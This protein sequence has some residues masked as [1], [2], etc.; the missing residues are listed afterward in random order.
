MK[1]AAQRFRDALISFHDGTVPVRNHAAEIEA[2]KNIVGEQQNDGDGSF[3]ARTWTNA[4]DI[5]TM[6]KRLRDDQISLT[7]AMRQ[8]L[9]EK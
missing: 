8:F 6:A 9:S 1:N 2:M 5:V 7:V 3:D 4:R